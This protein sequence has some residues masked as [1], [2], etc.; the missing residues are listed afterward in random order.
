MQ[1]HNKKWILKKSQNTDSKKTLIER[2]LIKRGIETGDVEE[3]LNPK[4]KLRDPF[5]MKGMDKA[6]EIIEEAIES[7]KKICIYGDYDVDGVSSTSMLVRYFRKLTSNLDFYIPNRLEEGY[8]LNEEAI[9]NIK[10]LGTDLIISVDCGITATK[11][12]ELAKELGMQIIIT[13]HH[14]CKDEI[15]MAD[16]IINPHQ[17]GCNYPFK[18]LCGAGVALKLIQALSNSEVEDLREYIE[19][20]ALATVADVVE[21][22]DENRII[23]KY[24]L[25]YM[26]DS[27]IEGLRELIKVCGLEGKD[28]NSM[29]VGFMLAPRLNAAGRL[30][31]ANFGVDLLTTKDRQE[32]KKIAIDLDDNN[33]K[34]QLIEA[35][36]MKEA[37]EILENDETY[38]D[39]EVLVIASD[40]WHHGVIGI[41]CS[42]LTEKYYKPSILLAIEDGKA[43][44]SARSVEGFNIFE[45]LIKTEQLLEKFGGHEQAAGLTLNEEN[46]N[47]FRIRINQEA[48][49]AMKDISKVKTFHI[50]LEVEEED[51][52]L[53]TMADLRRIEPYGEGNPS[54]LFVFR[55][56]NIFSISKI[57]K[58]KEHL[59][60]LIGKDKPKE[61][62]GFNMGHLYEQASTWEN[63][64]VL[65]EFQE[66]AYMGKT[67]AQMRL[68]DIR[69]SYPEIKPILMNAFKGYLNQ[70][71]NKP[72]EI[73]NSNKKAILTYSKDGLKKAIS[74]SSLEENEFTLEINQGSVSKTQI[75]VMPIIDKIDL[76]RYNSIIL[77]DLPY[78][79]EDYAQLQE[80]SI[81][82]KI[83]IQNLRLQKR[84]LEN[85]LPSR[86]DLIRVYKIIR[87]EKTMEFDYCSL[88]KRFEMDFLKAFV[89]LNILSNSG[90]IEVIEESKFKIEILPAPK[91]KLDLSQ[92]EILKKLG[93]MKEEFH[94]LADKFEGK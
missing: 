84:D 37:E 15:P 74:D 67:I 48:K 72:L 56:A 36:I 58:N 47:E 61:A 39:D 77:Y 64:D 62:I 69:S 66:N 11:E 88:E 27:E 80:F 42:K 75:I 8:G 44:G 17:L 63:I 16:S 35:K 40:K 57:G 59:K 12:V 94:R 1:W 25:S 78:K 70:I 13:D 4:L 5:L 41:V 76:K 19:I 54:P 38:K 9:T 24:G 32:A 60:M 53:D 81:E 91:E 79:V 87:E 85:L 3:Y 73:D 20:A 22:Q 45:S 46:L 71:E 50:D 93:L 49:P 28:I 10:N 23:V 43:K 51:I 92:N 6:V 65:F 29:H 86:E 83:S 55:G 21:L 18:N 30:G 89:C 90:L 2:L 52:S 68:K 26:A 34:R 14:Q 31:N 33:R 82:N 7:N